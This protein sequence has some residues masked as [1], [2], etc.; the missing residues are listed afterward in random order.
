MLGSSRQDERLRVRLEDD[1]VVFVD[2]PS[3]PLRTWIARLRVRLE[4][5]FTYPEARL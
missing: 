3:G 4:E 2:K 5:F 1:A